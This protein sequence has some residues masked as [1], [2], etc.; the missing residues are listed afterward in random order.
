[1]SA[2]QNLKFERIYLMI[3]DRDKYL[4][5]DK[6]SQFIKTSDIILDWWHYIKS[7]YILVS[8]LSADELT[9][10]MT[11]NFKNFR[12]LIIEIDSRNYNGWLPPNAWDWIH[13]YL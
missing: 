9:S 3:F 2:L 6:L 7:S 4:D 10:Y 13:K 8:R 11:E 5:Q 1:M 12:F